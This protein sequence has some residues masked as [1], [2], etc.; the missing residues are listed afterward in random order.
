MGHFDLDQLLA[1]MVSA[2]N[3]LIVQDLDGVC[4]PLVKDP[5]TRVLDPSYVWAAKKLQGT[6]SV[7]TNGEHGGRRGVNRLVE[8]A[9]AN[10]ELPAKQG[11][12]LPGLAAGGVQLQNCY[13]EISHPGISDAEISFLAE[14]PRRMQILLEQRLP[15]LLPQLNSAEIQYHAHSAVLDTEVSPTI[16]LNG[17]FSLIPEDVDIQQAMQLML[18][19]LM[20]ELIDGAEKVGLPDSFFLH[21]APNMGC[22]GQRERLKPA[23]PGDVGTTDIQFLLNGALKEAGLLVLINKHIAQQIGKA[24]LGKD[25]D[26]RSAPKTHQGLLDLCRKSIP[27]DQMPLLMGVGDTVTSNQSPDGTG[28]LRGGSDRGFLTLLQDLGTIYNRA[29][30][31]VLVDSSGGEVDRPSLVDE[32]LQG[33][34]DPEDPLKFDVLVPSGPSAY[35]AWFR[36]LAERRVGR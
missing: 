2:E 28:W 8:N 7:L 30:R 19:Q 3:L 26:V 15:A 35:V 23:A 17:L 22:D 11:L 12:Y 10:Q 33:I 13:G 1:E 34:S 29:N 20:D 16:N 21:V 32:R 6:F 31:V 18:Q 5:L 27:V 4:I 9:L 24:P 25:F 14:L 36:T